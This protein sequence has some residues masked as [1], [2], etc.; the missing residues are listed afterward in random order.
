MQQILTPQKVTR[1]V[2]PSNILFKRIV[3]NGK[4]VVN[5]E[6]FAKNPSCLTNT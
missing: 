5:P 2:G 3:G 4:N 1:K 6:M